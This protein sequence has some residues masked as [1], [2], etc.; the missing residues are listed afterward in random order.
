MDKQGRG[1]EAGNQEPTVDAQ[2]QGIHTNARNHGLLDDAQQN[3]RDEG[4][5]GHARTQG[6]SVDVP[7][8]GSAS[9]TRIIGPTVGVSS[10]GSI[11]DARTQEPKVEATNQVPTVDAP[12]QG[13]H[14]DGRNRAPLFEAMVARR[15]RQETSFHVP[16][17]KFGRGLQADPLAHF[18]FHAIME[19]D[20][21]E[22]DGMDDLHHPEGIIREAQQLAAE[23]YGAEETFFLVG[24]STAGNLALILTVC[25]PGDLILVQRN[26]HKSVLNGLMLA[27]ARA[28]FLAPE[29]DESE[30]IA[31]CVRLETIA[32]AL[33]RY[34]E[35]KAVFLTNPNYYG[36]GR[37]LGPV[38]ELVHRHG[39]PLLIDEAHGAHFGFH[40]DLPVSALSAGADGV[41]QSTHKMGLALT[42]GSM[43]HVQGPRIDRRRLKRR[44]SMIQSSSPSYPI[45]A[46]L[47]ISRS[48]MQ[49]WG[50]E[51][52]EEALRRLARWRN[53][54]Q[55]LPMFRCL[56]QGLDGSAR[57]SR[58]YDYIDPLKITLADR[59]G[60]LTG[61]E[62]MRL[63]GEQGIQAE[64]ADP[65]HVVLACSLAT[66][67]EDLNRLYHGLRQIAEGCGLADKAQAAEGTRDV[68]VP[69]DR[70]NVLTEGQLISEP[71]RLDV[72]EQKIAEPDA[73]K[74]VPLHKASGHLAAE[75]VI[76]YPPGIPVLYPGERITDEIVRA[77]LQYVE[78]GARF[79]GSETVSNG[80][81]MVLS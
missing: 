63:L 45:M 73:C 18:Y 68:D 62:L 28:V 46:S 10:E 27:G 2:T 56:G 36:M 13:A 75:A 15:K 42:M 81:M 44:L 50:T 66:S 29:W 79:Q 49:T 3:R 16:G 6:W 64:M 38:A 22:I 51:G 35:A 71:V 39:I 55:S 31:G 41:V 23:C 8:Q 59:T 37:D 25:N 4:T 47:D 61:F 21:T 70:R 9:D 67:E 72:Y 7:G 74:M 76:P 77:I 40:P 53:R 26:V 32:S 17:H 14:V 43:L 24:G 5:H 65:D 1:V 19:L 33:D 48:M 34:P 69:F 57:F 52:L 54:L 30:G 11:N 20:F 78:S 58:A 12:I 60:T 80:Q